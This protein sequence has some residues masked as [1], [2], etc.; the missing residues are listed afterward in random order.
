MNTVKKGDL[1]ENR[2]FDLFVQ[3]IENDSFFAKKDCCKVFKKKGYYSKDREKDIVF[4]ISIELFMP[5]YQDYSSL[6]LIECKNYNH[7]VPVNDIEEFF[8]K[9]QQVS[10]C[11]VKG[12]VVSNNSFQ[13]SAITFSKSKG[14]GLAK[15]SWGES[16]S[17]ILT[18]APSYYPYMDSEN[19][20]SAAYQGLRSDTCANRFYDFL[21]TVGEKYLTS[22]NEFFLSLF[23]GCDEFIKF[24]LMDYIARV[25]GNQTL[26]LPGQE[27]YIT[28][29]KV[30]KQARTT[31]Q[32]LGEVKLTKAQQYRTQAVLVGTGWKLRKSDKHKQYKEPWLLVSSLPDC[33]NYATKIAKCYGKRM[34]IEESFRDQ[35]SQTYGLGSE[36][37][38]TY[39]RKRLEVLLLLAALANWL[40][41]MIGLAAELAGKHLQFQANSIKHRRVLSFN[42][43]GMRLSKAAQLGL[44]EEDM[45]A[46]REKVMV[47]AAESDWAVI[48][49]EKS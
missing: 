28:V 11:N 13:E 43:L 12:I 46:A 15:Y 8:Q 23:S 32:W 2:I 1:L 16:L 24:A 17:W 19:N 3:L 31:P 10:G 44:T 47:W 21:G 25:R 48:K 39:K 4:D 34:Q 29:A 26:Q 6:V 42:Y 20:Y 18:R 5:G 22:L 30:Y 49:L 14:F 36:A 37:H 27:A 38:R 35:K 40:H 45:Q 9:T 41:Y 7:K 33:F